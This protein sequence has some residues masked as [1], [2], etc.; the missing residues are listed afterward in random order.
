MPA[1][2]LLDESVAHCA[3]KPSPEERKDYGAFMGALQARLAGL[4]VGA[5]YVADP[6]YHGQKEDFYE[7]A[8]PRE[9][10]TQLIKCSQRAWQE[11]EEGRTKELLRHCLKTIEEAVASQTPKARRPTTAR[12]DR[13][14]DLRNFASR[15]KLLIVSSDADRPLEPRRV[16]DRIVVEVE[17]LSCRQALP[18]LVEE[19]AQRIRQ[20]LDDVHA[21]TYR[22]GE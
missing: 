12:G 9:M 7:P 16:S 19:V 10:A 13:D 15:N 4:G 1:T 2:V 8:P 17:A 6:G 14:A 18:H 21:L 20:R 11:R 22:A 5:T 3:F